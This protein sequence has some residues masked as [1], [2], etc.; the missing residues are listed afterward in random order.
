MLWSFVLAA[1]GVFGL[2]LA[3]RKDPRG[4][5]IGLAAQGLWLVYAVTT[6][7]WGFL[8]S[9]A[10]YGTVYFRNARAWRH[11]R[12]GLARELVLSQQTTAFYRTMSSRLA[13]DVEHWKRLAGER[14]AEQDARFDRALDVL[15]AETPE[16]AA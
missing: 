16:R 2:W 8:L 11:P 4:W 14:G 1:V 9:C 15:A 10:A 5:W 13:R 12:P 3:G 7:Q 6:A